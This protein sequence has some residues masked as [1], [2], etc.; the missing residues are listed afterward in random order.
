MQV[1]GT[2]PVRDW[3][4]DEDGDIA[5]KNGDFVRVAGQL[6]AEQSIEIGLNT[7]LGEIFLDEA[8]GVDWI[9]TVL[10]KGVSRVVIRELLRSKVAARPDVVSV[11]A[12][13]LVD[14]A[15]RA[16][17]VSY[18]ATTV[19]TAPDGTPPAIQPPAIPGTSGTGGTVTPISPGAP[20]PVAAASVRRVFARATFMGSAYQAVASWSAFA[21]KPSRVI[22]YAPVTDSSEAIIVS[23]VQASI[24]VASCIV[25][26]NSDDWTGYVDLEI[27][28]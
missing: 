21:S 14:T 28:P 17:S 4:L 1:Q 25:S 15:P 19:Y 11:L 8:I 20:T 6:A 10:K 23:V 22:A 26:S 3:A 5:V 16:S 18:Q 24:G 12:A 27:I 2:G 13:D 7:F 9:N